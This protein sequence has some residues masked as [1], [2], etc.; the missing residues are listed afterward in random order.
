M[1]YLGHNR[2][3]WTYA[4]HQ[5]DRAAAVDIKPLF[6]NPSPGRVVLARVVTIGRHKEVEA[7]DGRKIVLFPGD[8]IAG[9]L[10]YRYAT[11]QFQGLAIA[12]GPTGHL[13]S[14]GGVCGEVISKNERMLDPTVLEWIG[15][16]VDADGKPLNLRRFATQPRG[17]Q[18]KPR[19]RTLLVVGASM[20]AG[21]T[22]TAAQVIRSLSGAGRRVA[23][24]KITGTA[25]RKDPGMM[26]DAGA[27]R[28]LDFTHF[29]F[30]STSHLAPDD[31]LSLASD[32]RTSLLEQ[33]PEFVVCEIADGIFQRETRILLEDPGFRETIDAVVFAG[34][35]SP[36][37]ECGVRHLRE[38]G[39]GVAAV[40][41]MVAN[42]RL[43]MEEVQ[44][45]IGV[46]CLNG[47]MILDGALN[48]VLLPASVA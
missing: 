1:D 11:D 7:V 5:V 27:T 28:V 33:E 29:G 30:P 21:K 8:V 2:I 40:A 19:P 34:P 14:V 37:C 38:W 42:S 23:A 4:T 36:A 17:G 48:A 32:M 25:C 12:A 47:Q 43:G 18:M 20:N 16:L 26:E 10:G 41:G 6:R 22:T 44:A 39:Y 31:L 45:A 46:P 35:D 13:L 24:A 9:V 3:K 15:G